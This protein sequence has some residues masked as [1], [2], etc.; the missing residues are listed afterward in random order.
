MQAVATAALAATANCGIGQR[1]INF[2]QVPERQMW[3]SWASTDASS[4]KDASV[5]FGTSPG[6]LGS[7]VTGTSLTYTF[8][9]AAYTSPYLHHALLDNLAPGTTYYYQVGGAGCGFSVVANFTSS[10]GPAEPMLFAI[11]GDL[12]Q[13]ANSADTLAHIAANPN[14]G[15]I[16]HVRMRGGRVSPLCVRRASSAHP[17]P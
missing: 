1:F 14:I 17:S 3:V 2:G 8:G 10:P 6:A 12:G 9:G 11:M 5:M 15:A 4:A 7:S 13:T 16:M